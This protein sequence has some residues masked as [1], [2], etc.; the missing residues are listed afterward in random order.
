MIKIYNRKVLK[1]LTVGFL[2]MFLWITDA[3]AQWSNYNGMPI[4]YWDFQNTAANP[5]TF[6]TTVKQQ[7]NSGNTFDGKFGGVSTTTSGVT[8]DG[9]AVYFG[10]YAGK[11]L[12][13]G[14]WATNTT[15]P[16]AAATTYYQFSLNTTGFTGI[17]VGF[18]VKGT[19]ASWPYSG[20]S[21]STD[22]GT[23]WNAG[24]HFNNTTAWDYACAYTL[25]SGANNSSTVKIRIYG[26]YS[27]NTA[28]CTL[29]LDNLMVLATG[30]V[31]NAGTLN[32]LNEQDI[33]TSCV[34]GYVGYSNRNSFT[35]TGPGTNVVV[36]NNYNTVYGS[37]YYSEIGMSLNQTFSVTSSSTVTFGSMGDITSLGKF[38]LSS[39]CSIATSNPNG[40][41]ANGNYNTG[42]G[43]VTVAGTKT[44]D[45]NASYTFNGT[46]AQIT[47]GGLPTSLTGALTINNSAGVTSSNSLSTSGT[48]V[49]QNGAFI[50][51]GNTLTVTNTSTSAITS[52][53]G[54]IQSETNTAQNPSTVTLGMATGTS[55]TYVYPFGTGGSLIPFTFTKTSSA[56][57]NVTVS[58][59]HT[60]ADN[61]PFA[62]ASD[63]G[64][65]AAVSNMVCGG[66]GNATSSVIDRWWDIY[67]SGAVTANLIFSY[68]GSEDA[69][70]NSGYQSAT[71][72]AQ[73]WNG[74]SWD[75][76]VGTGGGVNT[77]VGTVSVNGISTFSPWVLVASGN[78]LP[79]ELVNFT[80][81]CE[82]KCINLNWATA[83]EINND[84]F[85][86]QR[87][88]DGENFEDILK[89]GGAGNSN[90]MRNY[91]TV[92]NSPLTGTSFYRLK[93][94]D[95]NGSFTISP[96]IVS[97]CGASGFNIISVIPDPNSKITRLFFNTTQQTNYNIAVYDLLGNKLISTN[98]H[99][100][101]GNN[102]VE[103]N[104]YGLGQSVYLIV[105][106]NNSQ[107]ITRKIIF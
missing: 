74:S 12:S 14:G 48:I 40:I 75:T 91:S 106:S 19:G 5:T 42:N 97:D 27:N 6:Q 9:I 17:Q 83:S 1:H 44:F 46:A 76:P 69:T 10:S 82:T 22:G 67:A 89:I 99:A 60:G 37:P 104:C 55:L 34:P 49:L 54:Y 51:N 15:D 64:T 78:P 77:G 95:Y 3:N 100:D 62:A 8:G 7:V 63:G 16:G 47:N 86:V 25:P 28:G 105:L 73:H 29:V 45:P 58:T 26:W 101:S 70:M 32:L 31:A 52:T 33:L 21:Y 24:T 81:A 71:I 59:R 53:S 98:N 56:A 23:T 103:I 61:T 11:A 102:E 93:Q 94:T 39:G 18:D 36:N 41:S 35:V 80:S 4:A 88:P 65:V 13:A 66:G 85:T 107:V 79:I 2:L 30:T 20:I 50:L 57:V 43:S 90:E 38:N 87:S 92:D 72:Q 68:L 84:Y 96:V